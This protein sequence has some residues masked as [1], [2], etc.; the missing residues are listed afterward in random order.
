MNKTPE[1]KLPEPDSRL[2]REIGAKAARKLK[3]QRQNVP[4]IWFGLGMMGLIATSAS[5]VPFMQ[6]GNDTARYTHISLNA[7][8]VGLFSWQAWSG[9]QIVQ[10][11]L[12]SMFG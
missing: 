7:V 5:M 8:L 9:V 6:K 10:K 12:T 3:A 1:E 2:S 11:I 4:G